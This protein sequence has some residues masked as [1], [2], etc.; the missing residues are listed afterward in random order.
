MRLPVLF[1]LTVL[2]PTVLCAEFVICETQGVQMEPVIGFDGVNHLVVWTDAA[3]AFTRLYGARVTQTGVV[4]DTGGVRL[5][6]ESDLQAH[7][8]LA[9]DGSNFLV[10]WQYGC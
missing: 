10:T 8:A 5:L 7:P 3:G 4:L 6:S 1:F 9:F 2:M